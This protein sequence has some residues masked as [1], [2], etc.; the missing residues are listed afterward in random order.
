MWL[1]GAA[2]VWASRAIAARLNDA[3][4]TELEV[5]ARHCAASA[6]CSVMSHYD[7]EV[8]PTMVDL[9]LCLER[10]GDEERAQSV[11]RAVASDYSRVLEELSGEPPS[12]EELATLNAL[13]TALERLKDRTAEDDAILA[14]TRTVLAT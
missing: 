7:H 9:G 3:G 14:R 4:L 1:H 5:I 8:A 10:S 6:V 2:L 13:S 11:L 12:D